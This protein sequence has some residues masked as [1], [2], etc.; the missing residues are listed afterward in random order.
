MRMIIVIYTYIFCIEACS[1]PSLSLSLSVIASL[2][3]STSMQ[4]II[5][6]FLLCIISVSA[7]STF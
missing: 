4:Y 2:F 1:S 7:F 5:E 6:V 3:Y